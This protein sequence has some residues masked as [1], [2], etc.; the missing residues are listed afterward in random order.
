MDL[1]ISIV[2]YFFKKID[3][4]NLYRLLLTGDFQSLY[5]I[6]DIKEI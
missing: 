2:T 5:I 6:E 1:N 3:G 4:F